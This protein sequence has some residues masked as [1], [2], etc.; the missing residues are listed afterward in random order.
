[1][2]RRELQLP[3]RDLQVRSRPPSSSLDRAQHLDAADPRAARAR[4]TRCAA[5]PRRRPRPRSPRPSPRSRVARSRTRSRDRDPVRQLARLAVHERSSSRPP[6]PRSGAA[7]RSGANGANSCGGSLPASMRD[8]RVGG[9]RRQQDPVAP[10]PRRPDEAR[11]AAL[12]RRSAR[13]RACRAAARRRPRRARAPRSPAAPRRRGAAARAR[14]R[15]SPTGRSRAPRPSRPTTSA[16]VGA[17]HR[18]DLR[19][20]DHARGG[21]RHRRARP[22]AQDLALHRAAP[23]R[24]RSAGSPPSR[25]DS[26]P[27]AIT[28]A[29]AAQRLARRSSSTP[30]TRSVLR[31]DAGD[32]ASPRAQL[33]AGGSER[34]RTAPAPARA[35]RPDGRAGRGCR[36]RRRGASPG[37]SRRHSRAESHC[38]SRPSERWY[39]CRRAQLARPRRGR[40]RPS[41]CPSRGSRVSM[42]VSRL[43]LARRTSGHSA[44]ARQVQLDQG[45]LAEVGLGDRRQHPGRD[46]GRARAPAHRRRA[47]ACAARA[48]PARQP[49]ASPITPAP[50][51]IDLVGAP[52]PLSA[53]AQAPPSCAGITRIRF[54]GRRPSAALSARSRAPVAQSRAGAAQARLSRAAAP[55]AP[56]GRAAGSRPGPRPRSARRRAGPR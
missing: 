22:Q 31:H 50:T 20:A 27:A 36:R 43:Q 5:R 52:S 54:D 3:P 33:T 42:P 55:S 15:P 12:A 18:V 9:Q 45:L 41:A 37:S 56:S 34:A 1:M 35:A 4:P 46:A 8:D 53:T 24:A 2:I 17:R 32:R 40:P 48:A 47:R 19:R 38:A 49:I 39:S 6:P 7:K 16:A 13:C 21:Q 23:A 26:A 30:A 25:P 10:V 28:T 44:R 51:T 14:R 29:G 11:T